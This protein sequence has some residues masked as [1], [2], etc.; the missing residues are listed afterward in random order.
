MSCHILCPDCAEDLGEVYIAYRKIK[1]AYV[2]KELGKYNY[3]IET[4][5]LKSDVI[6]SVGFIF[7]ALGIKNQCCRIHIMGSHDHTLF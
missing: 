2:E 1:D 7:I 5:D 3:D 6:K 4:V